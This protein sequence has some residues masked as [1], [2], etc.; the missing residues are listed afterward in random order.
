MR[1]EGVD[2]EQE[3]EQGENVTSPARQQSETPKPTSRTGSAA[4]EPF[5]EGHAEALSDISLNLLHL[6]E[7]EEIQGCLKM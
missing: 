2:G 7:D 4:E 5:H 1:Q 6:R 3:R